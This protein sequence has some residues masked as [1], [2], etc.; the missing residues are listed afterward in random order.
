L[1]LGA[2]PKTLQGFASN[3]PQPPSQKSSELNAK[4][5]H[6]CKYHQNLDKY[7]SLLS[8][9]SIQ[10]ESN[11]IREFVAQ[12]TVDGKGAYY[13][14]LAV[15]E[16]K[17]FCPFPNNEV[18]RLALVDMPGLGDTGI[19]GSERMIR[20]LGRDID[21]V[22]FVRRPRIGGDDWFDFDTQL[23]DTANNALT[24]L[25]IE[26]WSF[27]VLNRDA[28]N[29]VLCEIFAEKMQVKHIKVKQTIIANCADEVEAN[30][31][32]LG[33]VLDYLVN[34]IDILDYRYSTACFDRVVLPLAR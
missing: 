34:R 10:I 2:K 32:I 21:F 18:G 17:I 33:S 9:D 15:K 23:Y 4:Y 13:N 29:S 20:T 6:L 5:E 28:S 1:G 8:S 22:L 3:L 27:M 11:R 19:G 12:D 30:N 24:E 31:E 16:V 14:C 7:Q 26:D 25:P